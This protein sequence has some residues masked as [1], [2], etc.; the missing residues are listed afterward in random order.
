MGPNPT[1]PNSG[2]MKD[3]ERELIRGVFHA[4]KIKEDLNTAALFNCTTSSDS[5]EDLELK[6]KSD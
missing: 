6:E 1:I 2:S 5:N 3:H 4:F